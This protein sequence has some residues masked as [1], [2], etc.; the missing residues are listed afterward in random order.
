MS[1]LFRDVWLLEPR[2]SGGIAGPTDVLVVGSQIQAV[3]PGLS[4]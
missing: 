4:S 3:G 1:T 2:S